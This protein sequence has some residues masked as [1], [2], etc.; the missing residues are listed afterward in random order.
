[1]TVPYIV[2]NERGTIDRGIYDIAILYDPSKPWTPTTPQT[3]WNGKVAYPF[4]GSCGPFHVQTANTSA[5]LDETALERGFAVAT[6]GLNVL[7]NNCNEAVSAEALMMV[8]EHLAETYGP[9]RYTIGNGCSGGSIRQIN[10]ASAYPGLLDG[11]QP[12]CTFPDVVTTAIEVLECRGMLHYFNEVSPH[13]WSVA[14]QRA[15][16]AGH[17]T[18][19]LCHTWITVYS[20][21]RL[22]GD[23]TWGCT[24]PVLNAVN[25]PYIG[26]VPLPGRSEPEWVYDPETNPKDVR[27]TI[28][29]YSVATFGPTTG[30]VRAAPRR[31]RRRSVRIAGARVGTRT[32]PKNSWT[33]TRRSAG[34]TSILATRRSDCRP[35]RAGPRSRIERGACRTVRRARDDAD[36]RHPRPQ[37]QRDPRRLLQLHVAR[38]SPEGERLAR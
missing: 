24:Q 20:F 27:C 23:P 35:I 2:R 29:D 25:L 21:D 28:Q 4:G 9:I 7:G 6:S 13:L 12:S 5:V 34:S 30:R 18:P 22:G 16:V 36:H 32:S 37:Q 19:S 31:Q 11:I 14:Q 3:G 33:S 26:P 10:I 15:V 38:A 1:M 17:M 8:K